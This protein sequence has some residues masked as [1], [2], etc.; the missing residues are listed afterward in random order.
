MLKII[1]LLIKVKNAQQVFI[2][3]TDVK[4]FKMCKT[5]LDFLLNQ[6]LI[7]GYKNVE[8]GFLV[9]LKYY[10]GRYSLIN[11]LKM[12]STPSKQV[13]IKSKDLNLIKDLRR[14]KYCLSTISG[15]VDGETA[16]EL[17]LGGIVLFVVR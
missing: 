9:N 8:G 10:R 4:N 16:K 1:N 3:N 7:V 11:R 6:G 13:Y 15:L 12:V 2:R 17:G 14:C 5:L